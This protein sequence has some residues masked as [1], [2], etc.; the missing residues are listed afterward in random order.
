MKNRLPF[1]VYFLGMFP[2]GYW[3]DSVRVL[4]GDGM[5]FVVVIGY[6]LAL[7][8]I[9]WALV[10]FADFRHKKSIIEHNRSVEERKQK[11]GLGKT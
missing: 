8:L 10:Q 4:L 2:L 7:R 9:G 6:L 3:Q 1:F 11:H 5:A